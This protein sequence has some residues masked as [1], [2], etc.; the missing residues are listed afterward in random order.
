[1]SHAGSTGNEQSPE[2]VVHSADET[3][4]TSVQQNRSNNHSN[5]CSITDQPKPSFVHYAPDSD[6]HPDIPSLTLNRS[7]SPNSHPLQHHHSLNHRHN[8]VDNDDSEVDNISHSRKPTL[9]RSSSARQ[10]HNHQPQEHEKSSLTGSPPSGN[11][12][13]SAHLLVSPKPLYSS[14]KTLAY[15][16]S[17]T[18][19][20]RASRT[21][22]GSVA[23]LASPSALGE[24]SPTGR[25][26]TGSGGA[27][28]SYEISQQLI[29]K[30]IGAIERSYGGAIARQAAFTIQRAYRSYRLRKRFTSLALQAI[31]QKKAMMKK[32]EQQQQQQ[33]VDEHPS[34]PPPPLPQAPP[35]QRQTSR[36][37]QHSQ[38]HHHHHR[39]HHQPS[40]TSGQGDTPTTTVT[41]MDTL[42]VHSGGDDA[43]TMSLS[44]ID[45]A[46]MQNRFSRK[47]SANFALED[48][49]LQGSQGAIQQ[50]NQAVQQ[51]RSL[52]IHPRHSI[53]PGNLPGSSRESSR[54]FY[55]IPRQGSPP[56]VVPV[57][58][59]S[60]YNT[61]SSSSSIYHHNNSHG[62]SNNINNSHSSTLPPSHLVSA[63]PQKT[64][65]FSSTSS[66]GSGSTGS[67]H[68]ANWSNHSSSRHHHHSHSTHTHTLGETM[69]SHTGRRQPQQQ[70]ATHSRQVSQGGNH[71]NQSSTMTINRQAMPLTIGSSVA[72]NSSQVTF[73]PNVSEVSSSHSEP[74]NSAED[75]YRKRRYR[76]GLNLFNK[77]PSER[78]IKFLIDNGFIDRHDNNDQQ[79]KIVA[80]FLHTRKGM[81]RQMIGEYIA[82]NK[83]FNKLV[84]KHFCL[85]I[86]F[87]G[88][89]V[90]EALRYFQSFFRFPGEFLV[91]WFLV[92]FLVRRKKGQLLAFGS[93][94]YE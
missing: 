71:S 39:S 45:R 58:Y 24:H 60:V 61:M 56:I 1:M 4:P 76:V 90:D 12:Q 30:Q 42:Q 27:F 16:S 55:T 21:G 40:V 32:V 22:G 87:A 10:A 29:D 85:V 91:S 19:L 79:A 3:C 18:N 88:T 6:S 46:A 23:S 75:A 7:N 36:T 53:G 41:R 25:E 26:A 50:H 65:S 8:D 34:S 64:P 84:L 54:D 69:V 82:E 38:H 63:T 9:T 67:L 2:L 17:V 5:S 37:S 80:Q 72:V 89:I 93:S 66:T 35:P 15:H 43:R 14:G 28:G 73:A 47:L 49:R 48:L 51:Q 92:S 33:A 57:A 78:G 13:D 68:G 77:S 52:S 70:Q 20:N 86:D 74:S 94:D 81:S 59:E 31:S 11:H 62:N 83:D 44:P